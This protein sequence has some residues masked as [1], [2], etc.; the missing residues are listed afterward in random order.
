MGCSPSCRV[1]CKVSSEARRSL[2]VR[3][4]SVF[5]GLRLEGCDRGGDATRSRD[6]LL[7]VAKSGELL[8]PW[9]PKTSLADKHN[10]TDT[11]KQ[12]LLDE[13]RRGYEV[14]KKVENNKAD[15]KDVHNPFHFFSNDPFKF[16]EWVERKLPDLHKTLEECR[17]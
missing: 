17:H 12:I 3:C 16:C 11:T 10:V 4:R 13:F 2:Q 15:W 14:V 8:E 7:Q 5:L 1:C 9:K 6:A